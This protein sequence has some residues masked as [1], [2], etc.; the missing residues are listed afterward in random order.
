M[1]T[2][3]AYR[4]GQRLAGRFGVGAVALS[5]AA[6]TVTFGELDDR[7]DRVAAGLLAAGLV[8][9]DRVLALL[10]NGPEI[11]ELL[12][13]CAR[14]GLVLVPMNWRLAPD[15]LAGVAAD[16]GAAALFV[17][18]SFDG[19]AG[20]LATACRAPALQVRI[21]D[22]GP[23]GPVD[24][25]HWISRQP[26]SQT[27]SWDA[28]AG[29][30]V[31]QV[32]TSGTTAA[33]KGV[34]L[35]HGNL[36][37]KVPQ[38][39]RLWRL[40]PGSVSLLA[41]P[42]FHIGGLSWG[43]IGLHAGAR[44]LISGRTGPAGLAALLRR[45]RVTHSFLVPTMLQDLCDQ[46]DGAGFPDLAAIVFGAAPLPERTH[47][48]A[49]EVFRCALI[50]VYGL[51]ETTGAITQA[52][53]RPQ[54]GRDARPPLRS[55]G[56]PFPWVELAIR[57]PGTGRTLPAGEAGEVWTRSAQNTPGYAGQPAATA[58]LLTAD[59]WLRTGD[60]GYLDSRGYLY[61]TDR[62]KDM[63]VTGGEN[64]YPAEVEAVL[65]GHRD[66]AEVVVIGL[67]DPR[68]GE[69]VTAVV[70]PRPGSDLRPDDVVAYTAGRLAS[71]KRPRAAFLV[72]ALP[73]NATGKVAKKQLI[74]TLTSNG[75]GPS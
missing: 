43:L 49:L 11:F 1:T 16:A 38:A 7:A 63:I 15:E 55:A 27:R 68:W 14:A 20:P 42:L 28:A 44:T 45:E 25:E 40:G 17:H 33:P 26:A 58:D 35:T 59:G 23:D 21:G 48:A 36:A 8:P 34:L 53:S 5:T 31:L 10:P 52:A 12:I 3:Q 70:V 60:G 57:E 65:G 32:Y 50:H 56:R 73:R 30:V 4:A 19:V 75:R 2:E 74:D 37:A 9:A 47:R 54:A 46:A 51:T 61:L 6:R 39:A 13:G 71:Y 64:V 24:Y 62:L 41:T 18:A 66:V 69:S 67:P 22:A 29:D 72:A